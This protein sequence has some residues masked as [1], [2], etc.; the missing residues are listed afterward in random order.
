MIEH[1]DDNEEFPASS[2]APIGTLGR[3]CRVNFFGDKE[4]WR[5][6]WQENSARFPSAAEGT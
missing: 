2:R 6:W 4:R 3:A 1:L 5:K